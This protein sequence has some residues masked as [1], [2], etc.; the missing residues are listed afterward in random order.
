MLTESTDF[1][2]GVEAFMAKAGQAVPGSPIMPDHDVRKLRAALILEECLETINALG[3]SVYADR[4]PV[5][6]KSAFVVQDR[7]MDFHEIVDGCAD[8]AVVTI[9]TLSACGVDD[10][11]VLAA[12]NESNMTKF[13]PGFSIREDGKLIKSPR[14]QP[15]KYE[16][17]ERF[18]KGKGHP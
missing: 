12:V 10:G 9:G 16:V 1:Q 5:D 3:F 7:G 13:L 18:N 4:T 15:A 17:V 8:I 11:P 6:K 14:Y 2:L